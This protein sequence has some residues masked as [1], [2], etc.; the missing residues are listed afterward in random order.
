[1]N[2]KL[3][4]V[5]AALTLVLAG[6]ATSKY[7]YEQ[8]N[9]DGSGVK[10]SANLRP[11]DLSGGFSVKLGDFELSAGEATTSDDPLAR[12]VEQ[13][14]PLMLCALNPTL[15]AGRPAPVQE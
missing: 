15:C 2:A 13:S 14:F 3:T 6:C 4:L 1:M 7:S 8:T 9:S 12:M 10:A 11:K 5:A